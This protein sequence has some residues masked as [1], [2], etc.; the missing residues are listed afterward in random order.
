MPAAKADWDQKMAAVFKP[1]DGSSS[2]AF[3]KQIQHLCHQNSIYT[4]QNS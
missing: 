1:L 2:R 4:D 3:Y